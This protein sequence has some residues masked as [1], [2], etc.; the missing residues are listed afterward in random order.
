MAYHIT[1]LQKVVAYKKCRQET[2]E[3]E[4][5]N[6]KKE[7]TLYNNMFFNRNYLFG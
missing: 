2:T 5:S 7:E 4:I 3:S 1:H 6:M